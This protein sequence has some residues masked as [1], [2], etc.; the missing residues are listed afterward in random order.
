[1]LVDVVTWV[2]AGLTSGGRISIHMELE[3]ILYIHTYRMVGVLFRID[4]LSTLYTLL[5]SL[6][7]G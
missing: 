1:M 5:P 2:E 7:D 6:S 4:N 3:Y